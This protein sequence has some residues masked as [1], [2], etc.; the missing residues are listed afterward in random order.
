ML[1][2]PIDA[3]RAQFP[4][5]SHT[6]RIHV[7]NP[8]GTQVPMRVADAVAECLL[9]HN[10]NLGGYFATSGQAR[11]LIGRMRMPRCCTARRVATRSSSARA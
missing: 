2:F 7:D 10:A 6:D 11:L 3:I 9:H 8:A 1:P 4:A 5:L